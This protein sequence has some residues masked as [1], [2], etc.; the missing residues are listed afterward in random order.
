MVVKHLQNL[1]NIVNHLQ[2]LKNGVKHLKNLGNGSPQNLKNGIQTSTEIWRIYNIPIVEHTIQRQYRYSTERKIYLKDLWQDT[3]PVLPAI[4]WVGSSWVVSSPPSFE[5]LPLPFVPFTHQEI[6]ASNP[7]E[8]CNWKSVN[9]ACWKTI[10]WSEAPFYFSFNGLRLQ[11]VNKTKE[12]WKLKFVGG[13]LCLLVKNW[14]IFC[15]KEWGN[16]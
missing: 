5:S 10:D 3:S 8:V 1:N 2:N 11:N 9:C 7:A 4:S 14:D 12:W 16:L 13:W 6:P 15:R